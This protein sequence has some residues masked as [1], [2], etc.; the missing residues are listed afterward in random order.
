MH[1]DS[2]KAEE[3]HENEKNCV[4]PKRVHIKYNIS[5]ISCGSF[6]NIAV[7]DNSTVYSW[8]KGAE[9]QLGHTSSS[10]PS[11]SSTSNNN[12]SN[13]INGNNGNFG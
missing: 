11:Q 4:V 3:I 5:K 13:S 2:P 12:G 8:G 7:A 6:H 9:G 10:Q 1:L